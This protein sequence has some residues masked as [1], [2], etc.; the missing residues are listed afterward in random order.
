MEKNKRAPALH[1]A[2]EDYLLTTKL[3]CGKYGRLMVGESG[4][5]RTGKKHYYYT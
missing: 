1:K 5:S 2:E 3:F 4:T